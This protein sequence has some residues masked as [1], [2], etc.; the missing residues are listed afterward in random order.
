[1][2]GVR[3]YTHELTQADG[4]QKVLLTAVL[5]LEVS[6]RGEC[7]ALVSVELAAPG[8]ADVAS[9]HL[10]SL[11]MRF[12]LWAEAGRVWRV[13]CDTITC[14]IITPSYARERNPLC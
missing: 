14:P 5:C 2:E 9:A 11:S 6:R 7:L 13:T 8:V 4:L 10:C 12:K 1:M 3:F